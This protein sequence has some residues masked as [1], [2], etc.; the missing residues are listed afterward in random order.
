LIGFQAHCSR[1]PDHY[2]AAEKEFLHEIHSY[3]AKDI[4]IGLLDA[5]N[6]T[7]V[8]QRYTQLKCLKIALQS[9][10]HI[11]TQEFM[12]YT[13]QRMQETCDR[14]AK[15]IGAVQKHKNYLQFDAI[16]DWFRMYPVSRN[17]STIASVKHKF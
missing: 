17:C 8:V 7:L 11:E 4:I 3:T 2:K 1:E 10:L 12:E 13:V 14:A 16:Q 15:E 9:F 6:F 5:N